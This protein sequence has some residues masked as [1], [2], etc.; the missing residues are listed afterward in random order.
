MNVV[1]DRAPTSLDFSPWRRVRLRAEAKVSWYRTTQG[2][3][4][5]M[6]VGRERIAD[7]I[8]AIPISD[9]EE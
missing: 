4:Y 6:P 3:F 1:A 7:R 5:S 9:V 8:A 2:D